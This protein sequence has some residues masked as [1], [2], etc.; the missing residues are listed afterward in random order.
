MVA[1]IISAE[2]HP[3]ADKLRVCLVDAGGETCRLSA[4]HPT[5]GRS[6]GALARVGAVLPGISPS[7]RRSCGGGIPGHVVRGE[8]AGYLDANAGL[9]EL[10]EDAP[11]GVDLRE[12]LAL[13][14]RVIE[15]GLTPNRAD[16]LG[17]AGI[18]REVG[19]SIIYR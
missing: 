3:D 16:C 15:I 8:G 17:I 7:K 19:C 10:A 12:Y 1:R 5:P 9:M 6:Q 11:V 13:D 14:D 18:A 2:Q 4:A